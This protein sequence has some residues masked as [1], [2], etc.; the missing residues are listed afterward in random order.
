MVAALS[1][2]TIIRKRNFSPVLHVWSGVYTKNCVV[3]SLA[4]LATECTF[5]P[6]EPSTPTPSVILFTLPL[7]LPFF[8]T[9]QVASVPSQSPFFTQSFQG[10]TPSSDTGRLPSV[11]YI[12]LAPSGIVTFTVCELLNSL[13]STFTTGAA[14]R[15]VANCAVALLSPGVALSVHP[16]SLPPS[17]FRAHAVLLMALGYSWLVT[18]L[19]FLSL[20]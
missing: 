16:H 10:F 5:T 6:R 14:S 8:V 4:A 9:R 18:M 12:S 3:Q 19:P 20:R 1:A 2:R 17:V 15:S 11:V 7:L 13:L